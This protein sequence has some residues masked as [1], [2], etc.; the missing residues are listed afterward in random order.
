MKFQSL[1][2]FRD[3]YPD[4]MAARR[5]VFDTIDETAR[6]YGFR[7]IDTPTLESLDLY[8]VKS[9]DEILE[10]T[11]SFED[12]GGRMVTLTPELTPV[13]ARMLVAKQ[14]ELSKPVKWYSMT[15]QW[16]YEQPQSGRLREFYQPNFDIFGVDG[17]E[18]DAEII[19][20]ANDMLTNLGLDDEFVFKTS[21]RKI[22]KGILDDFGLDDDTKEVVQ[23]AIDKNDRLEV[24][25][26]EAR[27][28]DAGLDDDETE[29]LLSLIELEGSFDRLEEVLD[30]SDNE[31]T[32]KGVENL[33]NIVDEV[34][35]YGVLD[36]CVFDP[37]I[38]R[39]LDYYTGAVFECFDLGGELRSIFGGGRYDDLI[40]EFGGQPTPAVGFAPGDATLE[41]LMRRAGVWPD[42]EIETDYYVA[43]IG[44]VR[45]TAIE[46]AR[47]LRERDN[48][49]E[50]DITNRGFSDQLSY[51]DKINAD[52]TVIV[53]ERDLEDGV[54]TVK[55]METGDQEQIDLDEFLE[56]GGQ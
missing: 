15:K 51:A 4:E 38:V 40:E 14:Q 46:V 29:T 37:S 5:K 39:G 26:V 3:F 13:V 7:E 36:S 52:K 33:R 11:Y 9:G 25:E 48:V 27:F 56:S 2:G 6:E 16:R 47:S 12:K 41:L 35:K 19:A 31:V 55:E 20:L 50:L 32:R 34:E 18:A 49:V 43:V 8:R 42:E 17:P 54:V 53:G 1:K 30:V 10:Q 21:H 44:D 45:E 23:R 28:R 24:G 22:V